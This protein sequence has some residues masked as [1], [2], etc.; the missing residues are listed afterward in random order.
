[1]IAKGQ[2]VRLNELGLRYYVSNKGTPK[3][4]R[5]EWGGR[6]GVVAAVTK[7]KTRARIIWNGNR[8]MADAMPIKFLEA[9]SQSRSA[10]TNEAELLTTSLLMA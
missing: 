4:S 9:A 8:S 2:K 1:M 7:D 6:I 3:R 5:R 10:P